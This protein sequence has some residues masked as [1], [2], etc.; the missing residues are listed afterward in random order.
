MYLVKIF[1]FLY[2]HH[3]ILHY[4]IVYANY[5][6]Y[7]NNFFTQGVFLMMKNNAFIIISFALTFITLIHNLKG[8]NNQLAIERDSTF[9]FNTPIKFSSS[10][11]T[12]F[13]KHTY[14]CPEYAQDFLPNNFAHILQF[15]EYGNNTHQPREYIKSIMRLFTNKLKASTYVNAYAFS[16]MLEQ[17]PLLLEGYFTIDISRAIDSLHKKINNVLYESFLSKFSSFKKEPD[18]FF[19]NISQEII[20]IIN[21]NDQIIDNVNAQELRHS[22]IRFL[23]LGLNRLVWSP[24]DQEKTWEIAKTISQ[25]LVR[26]HEHT[27]IND[28][29]DLN[30]LFITLLERYC[31][32]LDLTSTDLSLETYKKIK[33]DIVSQSLLLFEL[34]EQEQFVEKKSQ[35]FMRAVLETEAKHRA[36]EH[37]IITR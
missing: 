11:I 4:N 9:S 32:F 34:E 6:T 25:Q 5:T 24:D 1:L 29:D 16:D 14:N 8:E 20:H 26:L 21:Q 15:F 28:T 3:I 23:D 12:C 30:D 22:L 37:G 7:E 13:L 35:R 17:L 27:I 2:I 19:N 36:H 33:D 10:G 31:F 18:A